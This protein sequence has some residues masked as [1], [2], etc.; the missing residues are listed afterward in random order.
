MA[1]VLS[2]TVKRT[3]FSNVR[4]LEGI[5]CDICEHLIPPVPDKVSKKYPKYFE[6]STHHNDWGNDSGD[7]FE[8][9]D[10]CPNCIDKFVS[11]Y[12]KEA[13]TTQEI[14]IETK[15]VTPRDIYDK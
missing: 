2:K 11:D 8:H 15:H 13:D 10:I 5:R 4:A 1:K 12:L 3:I 7:S 6:V 14:D 9:F